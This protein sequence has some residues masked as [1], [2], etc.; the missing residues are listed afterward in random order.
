MKCRQTLSN[1]V[2]GEVPLNFHLYFGH[3]EPS[4]RTPITDELLRNFRTPLESQSMKTSVEILQALLKS[5]ECLE[6]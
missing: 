5:V 2:S 3:G 1:L 4:R 6:V